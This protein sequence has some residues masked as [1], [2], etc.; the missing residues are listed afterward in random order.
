MKRRGRKIPR[1]S[2]TEYLYSRDESYEVGEETRHHT[3]E[4]R[5]TFH[6]VTDRATE[7]Q[8]RRMGDL[9]HAEKHVPH[10]PI[11][12]WILLCRQTSFG[13]V[14]DREANLTQHE[15]WL[16]VFFVHGFA[17]LPGGYRERESRDPDEVA[18][19]DM[20]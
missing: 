16:P 19:N 1:G 20:S 9:I 12:I 8:G 17:K 2:N 11:Q 14:V 3:E 18:F 15:G 13:G 5:E 10:D 7:R 4:Q 6:G